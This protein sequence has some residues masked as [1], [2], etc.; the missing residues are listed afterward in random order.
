MSKLFNKITSLS[1]G[2]LLTLL[3]LSSPLAA[4]GNWEHDY[5]TYG[6]GLSEAQLAETE[7]L[8]G[9]P[10]DKNL[11]KIVVTGADYKDFTGYSISDVGM[12]SS[13]VITK[14]AE[15]SGIH[16]YIN[17]PSNI[18]QIKDH[19]YMNAALTSGI[20]DCNI[21]V[22]S[23]VPV[24]GESALIGVYKAFEDAGYK[25]NKNA[26]KAATD[27]LIVVNEINQNNS[28]NPN[29]N[30]ED[31]SKAIATIK[32]QLATVSDKSDMSSEQILVTINNVL[33][34]YN[35][36]ISEADQQKLAGWLDEFRALDINWDAIGKE[37]SGLGNLISD[38]AGEI[39]EWGQANGFWAKLWEAVQAFF[40]SLFSRN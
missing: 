16:V 31:F 12:Y 25:L 23:P 36:T 30:S 39:Y 13:A 26:T 3:L 32:E 7:R 37:L 21:V 4:K 11:K 27:E 8:I 10:Q 34:Q 40:N 5:F 29:F 19:Q 1:L 33:N 35:I 6:A 38:K 24:T 22:G 17:T 28:S 20:T 9:V 15:G 18:T 14:T 2:L